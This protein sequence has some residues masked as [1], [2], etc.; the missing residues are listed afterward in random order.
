[1]GA[2]QME[3]WVTG[4]G[5]T[6]GGDAGDGRTGVMYGRAS[7]TCTNGIVRTAA[8]KFLQH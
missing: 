5:V 2:L 1:M 3:T 7:C 6:P 8:E 4:A